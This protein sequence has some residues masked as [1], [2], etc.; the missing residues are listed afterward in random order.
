[1]K[2]HALSTT[3]AL[4]LFILYGSAH[5]KPYWQGISGCATS[6]GSGPGVETWIISCVAADGNNNYI[7]R[8]NTST[9]DWDLKPNSATQITVSAD[10]VPW[11]LRS[12]GSIWKWNGSYFSQP[13]GIG[14][15]QGGP[16]CAKTIAV[17]HGDDAWIT[18]CVSGSD[19]PIFHWNGSQWVVPPQGGSAR[20]LG[21]F[22]NGTP[23]AVQSAGWIYKWTTA[24]WVGSGGGG[25]SITDYAVLAQN[26]QWWWNDSSNQW[27]YDLGAPSGKTLQQL[28]NGWAITTDHSIYARRDDIL[29]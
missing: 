16:S 13:N 26:A 6:I 27:I 10:G 17:G 23:W 28:A 3:V 14:N 15:Y 2:R 29:H 4:F 11:V 24:G 1:M 20:Y 7:Y 25:S 19:T 9:S 8:W 22:S 12:D 18:S 21:M 5:A